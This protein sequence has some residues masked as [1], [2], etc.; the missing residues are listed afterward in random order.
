MFT[1]YA[2]GELIYSPNNKTLLVTQPK[3][4][5][6]MGKAGSLDFHVP[7]THPFY[8]QLGR[9]STKVSVLEDEE[10]ELFR[11]RVLSN[12]REFHNIR[13]VFCEGDLAYLVDSVQKAEKFAGKTHALFRKIIA[14]HNARMTSDKQF[15]V[16]VIGIEDRDILLTGQSD[17][18]V[19][20][21]PIDY[22]QIVVNSVVDNWNTT[23]DFIQNSLIDYAGGYLRTRRVNGVS[24]IDLLTTYGT[25][26]TQ[27]IR[28]NTNMLDFLESVS[29]E[30]LFT[31]LIPLGDDNL[32][33]ASVNNGS[34][35]LV[36]ADAVAQYGRIVRTQV[37]PNVNQAAT[38]LENGQRYL[39]NNI[40]VPKTFTIQAVDL[41]LL[42]PDISPIHV[43]DRV[44]VVSEA[45][46]MSE[47]MTCTKIEYDLANPANT[48][49]TFGNPKQTLTDRYRE[50]KRK[51]SDTYGPGGSGAGVSAAAPHDWHL[52]DETVAEGV[53]QATAQA[54]SDVKEIFDAW[55]KKDE[56]TATLDLGA[57]YKKIYGDSIL[58][59]VTNMVF[60]GK[61]GTVDLFASHT[62]W[63]QDRLTLK[64][65]VGINLDA[66]A[67]TINIY[68]VAATAD[69]ASSNASDAQSKCASIILW[70]GTDSEGHLGSN[71][72]LN[73][74]LVRVSN[75]L[76]AI[77]GVFSSISSDTVTVGRYVRAGRFYAD[78]MVA[79]N[80]YDSGSVGGN[81]KLTAK[82][83]THEITI[84]NDGTVH[85]GAADTDGGDHFFNIADTKKYKDGVSA[86]HNAGA[87]T[88]GISSVDL[89]VVEA[90]RIIGSGH[91]ISLQIDGVARGT[92]D[93]GSYYTS[94]SLRVSNG[95]LVDVGTVYS[96]GVTAGAQT[97]QV[98]SV[99]LTSNNSATPVDGV[100]H[101]A[102]ATIDAVAKGTLADGS[103]YTATSQRISS[104]RG[105]LA[106]NIYNTGYTAGY[107]AAPGDQSGNVYCT[108]V[109]LASGPH[110]GPYGSKY[111]TVNVYLSNGNSGQY[112]VYYNP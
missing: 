73:A 48:V 9:L 60:S 13:S 10:T 7:P 42:N 4:T 35:E 54:A 89:T 83:H 93:D 109:N 102:Y 107:N 76:E 40:N 86:A 43:G 55:L 32:T 38:L 23:Y 106:N 64:N 94:G 56:T 108:S 52:V 59:N 46:G 37:F 53:E 85:I 96:D 20:V 39:A 58:E 105:V 70:A 98:D 8:D 5:L 75:R 77:E 95:R 69:S 57:L 92:Y 82:R 19:N 25:T 104:A 81:N 44:M 72:A 110:S 61:S 14:A 112:N 68:S 63:E 21:G 101:Y 26:A 30:D 62:Q 17:E 1:I 2:N 49:Y 41:H 99:T 16:G 84:D 22:R 6:E 78:F 28:I 65:Q 111:L 47:Y 12:E 91:Y 88:A 80:F 29:P 103:T 90:H 36:D 24:Y 15:T 97:A 27:E 51:S 100:N 79:D 45:H 87:Q 66:P 34:D 50:D 3:L 74:D 18:E 67:G 71:I 33:I 31:V 11:G